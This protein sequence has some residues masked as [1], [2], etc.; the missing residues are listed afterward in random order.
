MSFDP[1]AG[2]KQRRFLCRGASNTSPLN[3]DLE[4]SFLA[5]IRNDDCPTLDSRETSSVTNRNGRESCSGEGNDKA[6]TLRIVAE[7]ALALDW[8]AEDWAAW[9]F[10]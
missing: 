5:Q 8:L 6:G 10:Y 3:C 9:F 2:K 7:C 1:Y 4:V